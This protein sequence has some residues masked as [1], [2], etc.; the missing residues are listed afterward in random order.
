MEGPTPVSALIHAATMVTAGVFLIIRCSPI[1]E[2]APTILILITFIGALTA[3]FASTIGLVQHDLKKII[4]YSTCSQLGYMIFACGLSNYLLSFYH[5]LTHACF[6]ALLFLCAGSIIHAVS[7]E[8]DMRRL[9]GL[10][11]LLP[12]TY[13]MMLIGSFAL[14]G[15]PFFAGFYSKDLIIEA[16]AGSFSFGSN[17]I[18]WVATLAAIFTTI[19]STR[20]LFLT[21]LEIPNGY[22]C[23]YFTIHE[24]PF[25]MAVP[26]FLL[27]I[28]SI[29]SGF[30][31]SDIFG[32]L[33]NFFF[34]NSIFVLPQNFILIEVEFF[35]RYIKI[36]PIVL[37][38][39]GFGGTLY[40]YFYFKFF[41]YTLKLNFFSLY[42]FLVKKWFF[43]IIYNKL[44]VKPFF[45][46]C[47]TK[48]YMVLDKGVL[49]IFG[50]FGLKILFNHFSKQVHILHT[51]ILYQYFCFFLFGFLIFFFFF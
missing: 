48:I 25:F 3:F 7:D 51:N 9:G 32:I 20:L 6:K 47:Y 15:F 12:F 36:I 22:R 14:I 30:L 39:F 46:F 16:S 8:Q 45:S 5:L 13:T 42:I 44:I 43:D 23:F 27:A 11:Q 49:E 1:F 35:P 33:G 18:Y 17:F 31:F 34:G 50:P 40:L 19:Y 24:A 26:L 4:A 28:L 10:R 37:S 38:C 2:Y 41:L 21:F 29:F